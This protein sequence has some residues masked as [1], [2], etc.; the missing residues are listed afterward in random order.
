MI[1]ELLTKAIF[2]IIPA[3]LFASWLVNTGYKPP[4]KGGKGEGSPSKE[5]TQTKV[6]DKDMTS[7]D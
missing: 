4:K 2:F 7:P 1:G 5:E 6:S 3:F